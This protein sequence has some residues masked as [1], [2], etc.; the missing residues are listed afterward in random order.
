MP[1][2]LTERERYRKALLFGNP[3]RFPF[4]PGWPRESTLK[5]WHQQGLPPDANWRE[6]LWQELAIPGEPS[7]SAPE[8]GVS[9]TMIPIF[10]EKVL[11]HTAGHII[12]QDWMGAITEISDE[13]DFSYIRSARDFVTRKWHAFPVKT[14]QDWIE[15][16]QWRY[17][18]SPE[19][20]P[21]DFEARCQRVNQG[22]GVRTLSLSGPFWQLREWCGFESLC[23]FFIEQPDFVQ[24]MIEFWENFVLKTL[25]PI[26]SRV[27]LDNVIFSE[28][29]AYKLHSMISPR[30][31]RRFLLPTY[32]KWVAAIKKSGCPLISIDSD[33]YIAELIPL[34]IEAG[35]N[36]CTPIEVAAGNNIVEFRERF[37]HQMAYLGGIDKRALAVGGDSMQAEVLRVVPPLLKE[38]GFI[39]SVD[40]GVPPDISWQNFI[41]YGRLL[42]QLSGWI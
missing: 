15:K 11:E 32:Q 35:L 6:V 2:I 26:L 4:E 22:D 40:H 21:A 36:C 42:A 34:W 27:E 10:E 1:T 5:V 8:L 14:R 39:P 41:E 18:S 16:I 9:F 28:D 30:M 25:E 38:G 24:E 13:Y 7:R 31:V 17:T 3:D 19:R 23:L 12:I 29:M 20:F 37:G 33:G